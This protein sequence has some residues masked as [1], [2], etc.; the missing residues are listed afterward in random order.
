M[1]RFANQAAQRPSRL[2]FGP[3][4]VPPGLR[5]GTLWFPAAR[6]DQPCLRLY[7]APLRLDGVGGVVA[8]DLHVRTALAHV[9]AAELV[10]FSSLG[11]RDTCTSHVANAFLAAGAGAAQSARRR[12]EAEAV[13]VPAMFN[14]RGECFGNTQ[15]VLDQDCRCADS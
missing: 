8:G 4:V 7:A 3:T 5:S 15:T 13:R 1:G 9:L 2:H 6:G 10:Y 14:E 12:V 11:C